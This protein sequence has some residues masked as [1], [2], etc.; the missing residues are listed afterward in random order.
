MN[1]N[2]DPQLSHVCH[3]SVHHRLHAGL[4]ARSHFLEGD[5]C[6]LERPAP[7]L[8]EASAPRDGGKRAH[9]EASHGEA[10][11]HAAELDNRGGEE[12]VEGVGEGCSGDIFNAT[13]EALQ[14]QR[15]PH[16]LQRFQHQGCVSPPPRKLVCVRGGIRVR[17]LSVVVHEGLVR[18]FTQWF[19]CVVT[20]RLGGR[21]AARQHLQRHV[22]KAGA[23]ARV[24]RRS[25]SG[26]FADPLDLLHDMVRYALEHLGR[27]ELVEGV[28]VEPLARHLLCG[29]LASLGTRDVCT[30]RHVA[31]H[32]LE[33]CG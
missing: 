28:Q 6:E 26:S 32:V 27:E 3:T 20:Q 17:V 19:K 18:F 24:E 9:R 33:H 16:G 12:F 13:P 10:R 14:V 31:H 25:D 22:A 15:D 2:C 11:A 5:A 1:G 21:H 8:I 7:Q 23:Q 4:R 29:D 30:V